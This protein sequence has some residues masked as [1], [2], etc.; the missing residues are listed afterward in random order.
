MR[1]DHGDIRGC[2]DWQDH[3]S[4]S[5]AATSK[6]FAKRLCGI[7]AEKLIHLEPQNQQDAWQASGII[8]DT[9]REKDLDRPCAIAFDSIAGSPSQ[10]RKETDFAEQIAMAIEP[11]VIR[12]ALTTLCSNIAT[13]K[14]AYIF[15]NHEIAIIPPPPKWSE[16]VVSWG[17]KAPKYFSSVRLRLKI[18]GRET[19]S[20]KEII[21]M[22]MRAT[23]Y[24][25][26]F[27][28]PG[29]FVD[30]TINV[31]GPHL[32]IDDHGSVIEFLYRKN[33]LGYKQGWCEFE[34]RQL[35]RTQLTSEARNNPELF[36][37]LKKKAYIILD[38]SGG[39]EEE[40]KEDE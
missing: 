21:G 36:E 26:R 2:P 19:N 32:G 27:D 17:G 4:S 35:R 3:A 15:T 20:E 22:K 37:A 12:R 6:D 25:N 40:E 38:V 9:I 23:V 16:Q 24:K 11:R 28:P 1:T 39:R 10:E 33:A 29:R 31:R 13:A 5:E 30:F 34:G 7:N 14:I 18:V 8:I